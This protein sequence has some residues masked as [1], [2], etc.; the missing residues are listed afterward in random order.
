MGL[1]LLRRALLS[2]GALLCSASLLFA[3]LPKSDAPAPSG[4]L[5]GQLLIA[6]PDIGDPYFDHAVVLMVRHNRQGA[7]G[8][9]VNKPIGETP[10]AQI[11]AAMGQDTTGVSGKVRI[12]F[13]GPVDPG[14]GLVLHSAEYHR[15]R[16]V[17]IDGK[18]AMTSSPEI[19]R[20]IGRNHGPA[21]S[22]VAFGYAGWGP[23]QLEAEM[24]RGSWYTIP[25]DPKLVFDD[26]RAKVWKDAM[27]RWSLPL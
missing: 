8:I 10:L 23:G 4:S 12:F 13:G 18:V 3:E 20:D 19:L 7:L 17:A 24:A 6:A 16:T 27:A 14:I 1:I 9:I 21:K 15:E 25:E 22:L 2:L 26:D 11:L 5:A